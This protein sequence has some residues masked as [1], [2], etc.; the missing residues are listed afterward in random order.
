MAFEL[1]IAD[2]DR[3]ETL[4][5]DNV[6]H[7][8]T[9]AGKTAHN[10]SKGDKFIEVH[11]FGKKSAGAATMWLR[12]QRHPQLDSTG[13]VSINLPSTAGEWGVVHSIHFT[14]QLGQ[15]YGVEYRIPKTP[16]ITKVK[17]RVL[18]GGVTQ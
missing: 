2:K 18:K 3:W 12:F 9:I 15:S 7:P 14:T 16:V 13:W 1:T 10:I 4:R 17:N 11:L 5:A 8:L 6:W